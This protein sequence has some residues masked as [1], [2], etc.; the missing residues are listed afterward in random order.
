MH[1]CLHTCVSSSYVFL[2][3]TVAHKKAETRS[4]I[5]ESDKILLCLTVIYTVM[6]KCNDIMGLIS[7]PKMSTF[8]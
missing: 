7:S 6:L 3:L 2:C 1:I 8:M 4:S 5:N